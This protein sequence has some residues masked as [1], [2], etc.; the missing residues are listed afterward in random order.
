MKK[1]IVYNIVGLIAAFGPI[2]LHLNPT[3]QLLCIFAAS[4]FLWIS[5]SIEFGSLVCLSSLFFLP[6][7][8][9]NMIFQNSFGN[10]TIMF[11]LFSML[12]TYGLAQSGVLANIAGFFI[13]NPRAKKNQ[14]VFLAFYLLSELIIGSFI[15]PTTLFILYLGIAN[16]IFLLLGLEKED[17]FAKRIMVGTG[18][19][20]SISCAWTPIAHT[21]PLMALGYYETLTETTISYAA[22]MKY[23]IPVGAIIAI[24]TYLL[25]IYKLPK[26]P[27]NVSD[28]FVKV[29]GWNKQNIAAV[30]IFIGVVLCWVLPGLNILKVLNTYGNVL[31][32]IIGCILLVLINSLNVKEGLTK[33]VAWSALLLCAATLTLGAVLKMDQFGIIPMIT[34]ALEGHMSIILIVVF[35]VF[36][37]NLISNIVTTTVSFNIFVPAI[38]TASTLNPVLATI[39]IGFGASLAYALPSSIAHI[40]LTASSGYAETKDMVKY[41]GIIMIISM[42]IMCVFGVIYG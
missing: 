32:A 14:R 2:I 25:L 42:I 34:S 24:I 21:F 4:I 19:F 12:L 29:V 10:S 30:V 7:V 27:I 8:T 9:A 37:T 6:E 39:I 18:L 23:S 17:P 38:V 31:P 16:E 5:S 11:L 15:A 1:K 22:Y 28:N 26:E 3:I 41:G 33:G 13:D 36:L 35:T 20:A 40:A